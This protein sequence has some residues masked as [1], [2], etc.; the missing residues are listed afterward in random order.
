MARVGKKVYV[1]WDSQHQKEYV[2]FHIFKKNFKV[3]K[4]WEQQLWMEFAISHPEGGKH[5]R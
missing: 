5:A 4:K 3:E 2:L 1:Y